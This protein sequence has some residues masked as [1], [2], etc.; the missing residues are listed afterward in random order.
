MSRHH[1]KK[2]VSTTTWS[3]MSNLELIHRVSSVDSIVREMRMCHCI[4]KSVS[5]VLVLLE[6]L[7]YFG[8]RTFV[9]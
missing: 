4:I 8:I 3:S 1:P 2:K 7:L 6:F 9:V 5:N